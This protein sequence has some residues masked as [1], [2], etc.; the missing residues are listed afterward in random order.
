MTKE[1][2]RLQFDPGQC[3]KEAEEL[4]D[5][6]AT[7]WIAWSSSRLPPAPRRRQPWTRQSPRTLGPNEPEAAKR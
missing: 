2:Q 1:F 3:R 4:R 7:N 5:L 6:L